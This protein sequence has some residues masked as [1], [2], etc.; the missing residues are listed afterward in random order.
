MGLDLERG[1]LPI[2]QRLSHFHTVVKDPIDL[3]PSPHPLQNQVREAAEHDDIRTETSLLSIQ[4][5]M[6]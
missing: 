4:I 6:I 2:Y 3:C 1:Y 5:A